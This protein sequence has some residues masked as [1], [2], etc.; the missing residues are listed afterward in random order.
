MKPCPRPFALLSIVTMVA[1]TF[2]FTACA[3]TRFWDGG[4][5]SGF[6]DASANW[7][8]NVAPIDGDLLVFPASAAR[9]ANTNRVS[10]NLTNIS[11][12]RFTGDGYNVFSLPF[13]NLTNGVTNVGFVTSYVRAHEVADWSRV[14]AVRM[15]L[16]LR[17][18]TVVA[19]EAA[20]GA[21]AP[22]N[23]VAITFPSG[24]RYDRRVFT[25]TVAVRNKISYFP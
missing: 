3:A 15:G 16:L 21:S 5:T 4:G 12:I 24:S 9:L 7:S 19:P 1:L 20:V 18:P 6:W 22:V 17:S 14:V 13:I 25:T 23:G 11:A 2:S 8:N 10:G